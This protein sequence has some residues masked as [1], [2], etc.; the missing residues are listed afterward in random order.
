[1]GDSPSVTITGSSP[2]QVLN[3][4]L[5]KYSDP[6]V[7]LSFT[8]NPSNV[9][10]ALDSEFTMTATATTSQPPIAYQWQYSN[11]PNNEAS[12]TVIPGQTTDTLTLKATL[13]RDNRWYR[14]TAETSSKIA[15]SAPAQLDVTVT[16]PPPPTPGNT[17]PVWKDAVIAGTT[18]RVTGR[19]LAC[20]PANP[21]DEL[22]KRPDSAGIRKPSLAG[23][24]FTATHSSVDGINWTPFSGV[25]PE[26][27]GFEVPC[28]EVYWLNGTYM[29]L[30]AYPTIFPRQFGWPTTW[31]NRG[32]FVSSDG[33]T[34]TAATPHNGVVVP[35]PK[36]LQDGQPDT[37]LTMDDGGG[38]YTNAINGSVSYS[39]QRYRITKWSDPR[40]TGSLPVSGS[41]LAL[42]TGRTDNYQIVTRSQH[43]LFNMDT[44]S[45]WWK[46]TMLKTTVTYKD[47]EAG[48]LT[49]DV[50]GQDFFCGCSHGHY[51]EIFKFVGV[52]PNHFYIFSP[53]GALEGQTPGI[54]LQA[55][56][57]RPLIP[58]NPPVFAPLNF[59]GR[60]YWWI[61]TSTLN[62]GKYYIKQDLGDGYWEDWKAMDMPGAAGYYMGQP[63]SMAGLPSEGYPNER[64]VIPL[65]AD[66]S[67]GGF[68]PGTAGG[69]ITNPACVGI[70]YCE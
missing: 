1:V 5:P 15:K 56:I 22:Y 8:S 41:N 38:T 32:M 19:L 40:P 37:G 70:K 46:S 42:W 43:S 24:A 17:E 47:G 6:S 53:N 59:G 45:A 61:G 18:K 3:I 21:Y 68:L 25:T 58:M 51:N 65:Y 16:P 44:A 10:A 63:V 55:K 4:V 33:K 39:A 57:E 60:K 62:D 36:N 34:W 11:T 29:M 14:N 27:Q 23:P 66:R 13:A 9:T 28:N 54:I 52:T 7:V 50:P 31:Q 64:T 69:S 12:W 30:P 2:N 20:Q 48:F 67:W 26:S 49:F 35:D